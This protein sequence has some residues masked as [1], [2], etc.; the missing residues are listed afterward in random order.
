MCYNHFQVNEQIDIGDFFMI[1]A[2]VT[3]ED[4][5]M[6]KMAS[7]IPLAESA[8]SAAFAG[9]GNELFFPDPVERAAITCSR[10]VRNHPLPDGN[11]RAGYLA[12]KVQLGDAGYAWSIPNED[13][14]VLTIQGLA[15]GT[16]TEAYF[17][18]WVRTNVTLH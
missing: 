3:G 8:L 11:K 4:P 9:Y 13:D 16:I 15:A 14:A 7:S 18:E 17:I 1:A 10:I 2:A 5:R 12:L 6:L